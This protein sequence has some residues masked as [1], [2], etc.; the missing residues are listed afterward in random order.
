MVLQGGGFVTDALRIEDHAGQR[1]FTQRA[2]QGVVVHADH[3][4]LIRYGQVD[5]L[6]GIHDTS[7]KRV[8]SGSRWTSNR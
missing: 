4:H 8:I 2:Q 6:T 3:D 5:P 7:A 1:R